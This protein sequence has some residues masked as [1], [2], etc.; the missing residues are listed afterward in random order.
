MK[1]AVTDVIKLIENYQDKT[2]KKFERALDKVCEFHNVN[3]EE[4]ENY[5][6]KEL[7]EQLGEK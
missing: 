2:L 7:N 5:F 4:I 6:D 1:E 3:K